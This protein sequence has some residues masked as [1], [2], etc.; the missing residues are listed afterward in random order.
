MSGAGG[1][2]SSAGGA[3]IG[4]G[5]FSYLSCPWR[6]PPM[7]FHPLDGGIID[8]ESLRKEYDVFGKSDATLLHDLGD[9]HP[10]RQ[11]PLRPVVDG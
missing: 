7:P 8:G 3:S 4:I 5:L 9:K 10:I 1:G 6:C 11:P 2:I